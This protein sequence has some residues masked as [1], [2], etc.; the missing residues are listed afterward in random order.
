MRASVCE[1][2]RS[3]DESLS[4]ALHTLNGD[5]VTG[6]IGDAGGRIARLL[7]QKPARKRPSRIFTSPRCLVIRRRTNARTSLASSKRARARGN[8]LRTCNGPSSTPKSFCLCTEV[9]MGGWGRAASPQSLNSQS[10]HS[11][12]ANRSGSTPATQRRS[13]RF[14]MIRRTALAVIAILPVAGLAMADGTSYPMVMSLR[15]VAIQAGTTAEMTVH[16]RYSMEGSYRIL[17]SGSGVTGQ[18]ANDSSPKPAA[19]TA[20]A[21]PSTKGST[22]VKSASLVKKTAARPRRAS[23][24]PPSSRQPQTRPVDKSTAAQKSLTVQKASTTKE[25]GHSPCHAPAAPIGR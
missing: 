3:P 1:C 14:R 6:K 18:V 13:E 21:T 16:S 9:G 11:L 22:T 25:V 4:Q 2:E 24:P 19:A 15:P 17:I 20:Q 10:L 8:A 5:I 12:R 23:L 7:A